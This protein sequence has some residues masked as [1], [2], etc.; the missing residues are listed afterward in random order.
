MRLNAK[1]LKNVNNVN[2]W[3]STNQAYMSEGQ[4]NT[5]HLQIIDLDVTTAVDGE[6]SPAFPQYPMRYLSQATVLAVTVTFPSVDDDA[7]FD[8]VGSQAFVDDKSI[9]RFNLSAAQIPASGYIKVKVTED[10][11]DKSFMVRNAVSV[12]N[13]E[14]GGC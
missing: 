4:P 12:D 9:W 7:E 13:L 5:L 11:I 6:K 2:S 8:I 1:I 14:I 10:G 3:Q